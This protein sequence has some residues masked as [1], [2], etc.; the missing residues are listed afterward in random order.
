MNLRRRTQKDAPILKRRPKS[1]LVAK[2]VKKKGRPFG[3]KGKEK[4]AKDN[5]ALETVKNIEVTRVFCEAIEAQTTTVVLRGGARSS[6][7]YSVCCQLVTDRF[8]SFPGIQIL[9]LRK[10]LP[11]LKISTYKQIK[12]YM[13]KMGLF[14]YVRENRQSLDWYYGKSLI[15]FG[16]LDDPEK[17]KS[18]EW[19]IILLE[20]ATE[21]TYQDYIICKTRLSSP[22]FK[23][24]LNQIFLL[25]N[26]EDENCWIKKELI[27]KDDDCIELVSSYKDNPFLTESYVKILEGLQRTDQNHWR[28]YG[29]GEWGVLDAL[30]FSNWKKISETAVPPGGESFYALDFGFNNPSALVKIRLISNEAYVQQKL[31]ESGLTN[32]QLITKLL[33]IIPAKERNQCQIYADSAEPDRIKEINDAGFWCLPCIKGRSSVKDSIDYVKRFFLHITEDSD[34]LLKEIRAYSWRKDRNG[35]RLEEPVAYNDHAM[36]CIRYGIHTHVLG[37]GGLPDI[38]ILNISNDDN[39]DFYKDD[40]D[41]DV[42]DDMR[43]VG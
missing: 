9:V 21:F 13:E 27:D 3:S 39:N 32:T 38:K 10:T 7:S 42:F 14:R 5:S 19:N 4:I 26:P 37:I 18:S 22:K 1:L 31:Y 43:A 40:D 25:F 33:E 17:I 24:L 34:D 16:S 35:I 6:K 28:I 8:F 20:E 30:I 2:S 11:A 29:L 15:H 12:D 41:N 36:S 23:N